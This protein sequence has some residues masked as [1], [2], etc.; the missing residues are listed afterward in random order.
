MKINTKST[1]IN[2]SETS[3]VPNWTFLTSNSDRFCRNDE[4]AL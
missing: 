3:V 1:V 4:N 2:P